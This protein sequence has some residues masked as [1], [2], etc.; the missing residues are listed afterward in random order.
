MITISGVTF[1]L[2]DIVVI[3]EIAKDVYHDKLEDGKYIRH[4]KLPYGVTVDVTYEV[5]NG[6]LFVEL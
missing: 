2:E 6:D 1:K 3:G 4:S 5:C